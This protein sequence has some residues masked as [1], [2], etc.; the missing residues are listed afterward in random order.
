LEV[1]DKVKADQA[2]LLKQ[3][4][5]QVAFAKKVGRFRCAKNDIC[6]IKAFQSYTKAESGFYSAVND[7]PSG[8]A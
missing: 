2:A 7:V 3:S 1:L 4:K 6:L 5:A 8:C